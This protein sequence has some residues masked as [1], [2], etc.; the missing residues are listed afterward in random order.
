MKKVFTTF[1]FILAAILSLTVLAPVNAAAA[2]DGEKVL[3]LHGPE[4]G[5]GRAHSAK[6]Y[7]IG[8]LQF[9][10][11][12][13]NDESSYSGFYIGL[14]SDRIMICPAFGSAWAVLRI[15]TVSG[16][17]LTALA[18][19]E[20]STQV[21]YTCRF[22]YDSDDGETRIKIWKKE[23]YEPED[24]DITSSGIREDGDEVDI[25]KLT[26]YSPNSGNIAYID[27][28]KLIDSSGK[29]VI[30]EGFDGYELGLIPED[31]EMWTGNGYSQI[32]SV[33]R[34]IIVNSPAPATEVPPTEVPTQAPTKEPVTNAPAT[35]VPATADP[36][37]TDEPAK[38]TE[39]AKQTDNKGVPA[40]V[41]VI[42]GVVAVAAIAG[43][44]IG[45]NAKKRKK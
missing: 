37:A 2:E 15:D 38:A 43:V 17:N 30:D 20:I 34:S 3:E 14:G 29:L 18:D 19:P 25:V 7:A 6:E 32:A 5:N 9:D 35:A 44:I 21:W 41:W 39:P 24:W 27:N 16:T 33:D 10:F 8:E 40:Y 36:A 4:T 12:F 42:I 22:A 13:A 26:Y 31:G 28:V 11:Y 1:I 23:E 45:V